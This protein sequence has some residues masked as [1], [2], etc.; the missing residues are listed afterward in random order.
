MS[1][2]N[3]VNVNATQSTAQQQFIAEVL[4][5]WQQQQ[6]EKIIFSQY[7][8][9]QSDLEKITLRAIVLKNQPHLQA[10]WRY[11]TND[12]T[13]NYAQ[14]E[15][16]QVLNDFLNHFRQANAFLTGQELQLKFKKQQWQLLH[17]KSKNVT[18][19]IENNDLNQSH[20]REKKRYVNAQ[21]PFL[22]HLGIND[23]QQQLIAS[24]SRKWK[25][26]NKFI[27]IFSGAIKEAKLVTDAQQAQDLHVVDFGSGKGYLTFAVY[28]Y[29]RE[30]GF[31]PKVTGVELRDEL[32][33]FCQDTAEQVGF[34]AL[35]FF[36]GDVRSYQPEQTDVMIA[37]HACD[38][39]TDFAIHTGIRLGAKVIMTAPCCHKELRPQLKSPVILQPMLQFGVHQ[40]QQAEMLTDSLRAMMLQAY[41]YETK[42]L[43]F[44]S[45]EHTSKNKMI[46]AI[47]KHATQDLNQPDATMM[48]KVDELKRYYAIE[49]QTL[50]Q[51]LSNTNA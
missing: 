21:A 19:V 22:Q 27:E 3:T 43:E 7:R 1:N 37:L 42:I 35:K 29:L 41:G 33:Q 28:D 39:A 25:Q 23:H 12:V 49:K 48:A 24:M 10:T 36:Q 51:L 47:K 13:K 45:L 14:D 26:I 9:E 50:Q 30:H 32:V 11:K 40:G 38:I 20:N 17:S 5:A 8:G 2:L 46:L 6:L 34:D 18:K 16:E 4:T 44:V 31:S 15:C